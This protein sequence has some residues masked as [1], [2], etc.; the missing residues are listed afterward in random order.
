MKQTTSRNDAEL[1]LLALQNKR[2]I[3]TTL[4]RK[5]VRCLY[6]YGDRQGTCNDYKSLKL[7]LM[8]RFRLTEKD[9][10][11]NFVMQ[12]QRKGTHY[13]NLWLKPVALFRNGLR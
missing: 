4:Q 2:H 12:D 11:K 10:G 3:Y 5:V 1:N 13:H 8:E 6:S 9:L 7:A